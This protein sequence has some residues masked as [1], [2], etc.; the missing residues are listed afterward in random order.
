M[1]RPADSPAK[2][3][4]P[5]ASKSEWSVLVAIGLIVAT[6]FLLELIGV[7]G[8]SQAFLVLPRL[9]LLTDP[10]SFSIVIGA[11]WAFLTL[12]G[13]REWK[14]HRTNL[15]SIPI[16]IHVNGSRGKTGTCR[17]IGAALRANG[18]K[19]ITKTTGK[20]P[21]MIDVSGRELQIRESESDGFPEG[22]IREQKNAVALAAKQGA[23]ALVVECMALTPEVQKVSEEK[24]IRA[25]VG[26]ITNI[27]HDHLDVIGPDLVSAARN[28]CLMI[29]RNQVVVTCEENLLWKVKQE[30]EKRGTSV[31]TADPKSVTDELIDSFPYITFKENVAIAL[32]VSQL[33]GLDREKSLR[34]MLQSIPDYGT[35]RLFNRV[36][37]QGPYV[38]VSAFGVNDVDS[39][40]TV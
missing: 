30:A 9:A 16:R 33:L 22:N 23:Q 40:T 7:S 29:P 14:N 20:M 24:F 26:V 13:Y 27:R 8:Q 25:T 1:N 19:V 3:R 17:L 2:K 15:E 21:T 32:K 4:P 35:V 18:L 6:L 39:L 10:I 37:R 28:L 12:I 11:F 31:V 5:L 38:V 34:G 36:G